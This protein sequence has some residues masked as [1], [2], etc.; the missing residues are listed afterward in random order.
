ME[1]SKLSKVLL[2]EYF[3]Y[4]NFPKDEKTNSICGKFNYRGFDCKKSKVSR[5]NSKVDS[6]TKRKN[7]FS[8]NLPFF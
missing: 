2:I 3:K 8:E 4:Q 7:E 5:K 6:K 1:K